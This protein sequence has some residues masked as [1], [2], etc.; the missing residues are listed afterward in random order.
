MPGIP[1]FSTMTHSSECS[2]VYQ[3][4]SLVYRGGS[5]S[6]IVAYSTI[7]IQP[8]LRAVKGSTPHLQFAINIRQPCEPSY[9]TVHF[10]AV[11][12]AIFNY[13]RA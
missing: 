11:H 12:Y 1:F 13:D 7:H 5:S 2:T 10:R 8:A 4:S 6:D 3:H 9:G